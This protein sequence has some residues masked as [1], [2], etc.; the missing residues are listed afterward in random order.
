MASQTKKFELLKGFQDFLPERMIPRTEM[1]DT[2]KR[3]YE[4]Y[5]FMPQETPVLEY[6]AL[7]MD[8]YGEDE[9][10]VYKF[11]DNGGR[12]VAMR[13]DLTVPLSRVVAMNSNKLAFPY[14]RYQAGMVW[15]A[16]KPQ[17]GRF[18][19]FMQ[20]DADIVGAKSDFADAEI[21][22]MMQD[23]MEAFSGR[24]QVRMNNRLILNALIRKVG[25]E[26]NEG[27][28]ILIAIDKYDKI[29]L[30]GVRKQLKE[31]GFPTNLIKVITEYLNI[32]GDLNIVLKR[33][34]EFFLGDKEGEEG[35]ENL[36]KVKEIVEKMGFNPKNL[37]I[38]PTIARGLNYYTGII[39]ETKLIDL[40]GFGSICS[41]GRFDNLISLSGKDCPAVGTSVGVDRL[42]AA[43]IELNKIKEVSTR[44]KVYILN[45]DKDLLDE[46]ANIIGELR[47]ANIFTEFN[48]VTEGIGKQLKMVSKKRIP[49]VLLLGKDEDKLKEITIKNMNSGKQKTISRKIL[50]KELSKEIFALQ[51]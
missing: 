46:Y 33:L 16:D 39:Y 41:G 1:I 30:K 21:I 43:L 2:I 24:Y 12:S 4:K 40:P 37:V 28:G 15:R 3:V 44:T 26:G 11:N 34:S 9:K 22:A 8:K 25:K 19:E 45:I 6:A 38:D 14:K 18:R 23:T 13:Y 35:I 5:G 42:F 10:L 50:I 31:H 29:G 7:L 36:K 20:F 47:K 51:I 32:Q 27:K 49:L 48:Y 17:K